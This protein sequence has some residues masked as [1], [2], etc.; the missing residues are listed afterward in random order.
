ML[1]ING[2]LSVKRD[3]YKIYKHVIKNNSDYV[4]SKIITRSYLR[5]NSE[6]TIVTCLFLEKV[7]VQSYTS[8]VNII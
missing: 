1:H 5:Y 4:L 7:C 2:I 8:T 6:D 3:I